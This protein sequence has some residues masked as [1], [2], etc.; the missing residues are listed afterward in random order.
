MECPRRVTISSNLIANQENTGDW[1][2]K[3][4]RFEL[5]KYGND[6]YPIYGHQSDLLFHVAGAWMVSTF[7]PICS[8]G[9]NIVTNIS[10]KM[11]DYFKFY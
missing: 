5:T 8:P 4:G 1:K 10:N 3:L 6:G 2:Q 9:F 11:E 7:I